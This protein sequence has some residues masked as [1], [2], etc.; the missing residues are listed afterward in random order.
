MADY[1]EHR[2]V[3]LLDR[4]VVV[5][6]IVVDVSVRLGHRLNRTAAVIDGSR[7]LCGPSLGDDLAETSSISILRTSIELQQTSD[8]RMMN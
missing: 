3:L 1:V 6:N 8:N 2:G 7:T 5:A 4:Y